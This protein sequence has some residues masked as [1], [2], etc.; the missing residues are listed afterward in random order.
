[1]I[2]ATVRGIKPL[3]GRLTS[4][5]APPGQ[6]PGAGSSRSIHLA[7]PAPLPRP[8]VT[9]AHAQRLLKTTRNALNS[10][11]QQIAGPA[12]LVAREAVSLSRAY[13]QRAPRH[14]S[15]SSS[16]R[17]ILSRP[18][19]A[20]YFPKGPVVRRGMHEVG[21]GTARQFSTGRT[22]FHHVVENTN[23]TT[24]ALLKANWN[25][26]MRKEQAIRLNQRRHGKENKTR[27]SR[28]TIEASKPI[29]VSAVASVFDE[30]ELSHYFHNIVPEVTTYLQIALAATPTTRIPFPVS[31]SDTR[32]LPL[33]TILS[34][35]RAFQAHSHRVS[36][37]FKR[38]DDTG[39][40]EKGVSV[41]PW[42]DT[43][44]LCTELRV[45]FEG[46]SEEE[47]RAL[48]QGLL[49]NELDGWAIQELR[50]STV[51]SRVL[52]SHNEEQENTDSIPASMMASLMSSPLLAPAPLPD[53]QIEDPWGSSSSSYIM[54]TLDFSITPVFDVISP[55]NEREDLASPPGDCHSDR[56]SDIASDHAMSDWNGSIKS[57]ESVPSVLSLESLSV[58]SGG[59][60]DSISITSWMTFSSDLASRVG[61]ENDFFA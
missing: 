12:A 17:F 8:R 11:I 61:E 26:D 19:G 30:T 14:I 60:R 2:Q 55:P 49:E 16:A 38:L 20:F 13:A 28:R 50:E 32:L 33:R 59:Y 43:M 24:R 48:F 57:M 51:A 54:P 40:W 10:F 41:E 53:M 52:Q 42:G 9:A 1:M 46:W 34:S 29:I 22:V 6:G 56:F 25:T 21:L 37:L 35:H 3:A 18:P 47:V 31:Y 58:G 44:G 23:I 15:L 36:A 45:K 39:A 4:R 27:S 7:T 5:S